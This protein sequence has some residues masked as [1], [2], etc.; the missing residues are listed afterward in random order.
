VKSACFDGIGLKI[1][2]QIKQFFQ[3]S[4]LASPATSSLSSGR[5]KPAGLRIGNPIARV[6]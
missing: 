1:G 2:F 3:D 4:F 5:T 6:K